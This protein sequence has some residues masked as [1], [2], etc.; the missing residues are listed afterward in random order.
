MV[1]HC[2]DLYEQCRQY[3]RAIRNPIFTAV[4]MRNVHVCGTFA[5]IT[6]RLKKMFP[7][8]LQQ[9]FVQVL[10][11][12]RSFFAHVSFHFVLFRLL[13]VSA[14]RIQSQDYARTPLRAFSWL[15]ICLFFVANHYRCCLLRQ[16]GPGLP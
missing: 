13:A 3:S 9:S 15:T 10:F 1:H 16:C 2:M 7:I 6:V 8:L 5:H 12:C 14:A 4:L 11:H